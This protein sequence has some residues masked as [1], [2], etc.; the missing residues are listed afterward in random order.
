MNGVKVIVDRRERNS[1]LIGR[2]ESLGVEVELRTLPVGDYVLSDRVCIERK[3]TSDFESS[4]MSGRLFEQVGRLVEAYDAPIMVIEDN[5]GFRLPERVIKGAIASLYV[6]YGIQVLGSSGCL[7]TAEI[8]SDIAR[9]EQDGRRREPSLKGAA[10]AYTD[11]Q[12]QEYVI[13]NLPGIGPKLA[14][15]LLVHFKSVRNIANAGIK[16]LMEVEKIGRKK[17]ENIHRTVNEEYS[18]ASSL[19][20]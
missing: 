13:G 18:A 20:P 6:D 8:I 1:E 12:F 17:A 4:I 7:D 5:D 15:S 16:E 10:R 2:L 19:E 14:R 3:T 11:R 9:R